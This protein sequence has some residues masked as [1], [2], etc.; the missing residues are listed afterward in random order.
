MKTVYVYHYAGSKESGAVAAQLKE[1]L[2]NAGFTVAE[3]FDPEVEFACVVGGDGTFMHALRECGF[4]DIP[5]VRSTDL[6]FLC[7]DTE[8]ASRKF[9]ELGLRL[10]TKTAA[11]VVRNTGI[12]DI[13][14]LAFDKQKK[15][16]DQLLAFIGEHRDYHYLIVVQT[17]KD[18]E[19]SQRAL[20]TIRGIA[21]VDMVENHDPLVLREIY[22]HVEFLIT[23]RLHAGILSLS[24]NTPVIG[25]FSEEWGLKNPGM[26][27]DYEMPY[28]VIEKG[29]EEIPA[30]PTDTQRTNITKLR[31]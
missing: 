29:K 13:G 2:R 19:F 21:A 12:G 11:I 27:T 22:K 8:T 20:E 23:M 31:I 25:L 14:E 7:E 26:M 30:M 10:D 28:V 6:A 9:N 3:E 18:R 4:P 15:L 16:M 1:K 24:A 5:F 17:E